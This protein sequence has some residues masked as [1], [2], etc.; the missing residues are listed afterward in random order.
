MFHFEYFIMKKTLSVKD[1]NKCQ[2]KSTRAEWWDY[3]NNGLYFVTI[4]TKFMRPSF[5][6]LGNEKVILNQLGQVARINWLQ[7]PTFFPFTYL[8]PFII[9]PNHLHGIIGIE[10]ASDF[11][12]INQAR[13][14][15]Q[16]NNLASI[17]RGFKS[18]V[19]VEA[20][21]FDADFAWQARFHDRIIRD[22]TE[23]EN[24]IQYIYDNP[25]K[26]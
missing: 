14:G 11:L 8:G 10:K 25:I 4:C 26:G 17:I 23:L 5:G 24:I 22:E 18:S 1:Q 15:P 7:I 2:I 9:M 12:E 3:S 21:K 19:K 6:T 16:S 20:R 13:F